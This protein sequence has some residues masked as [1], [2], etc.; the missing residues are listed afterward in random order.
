[1]TK[2]F[3]LSD[4]RDHSFFST[5]KFEEDKGFYY[6]EDVKEFIRRLRDYFEIPWRTQDKRLEISMN[7]FRLD[8]LKNINKLAGDK[9]K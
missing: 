7:S 1:M 4:K 5:K 8:V 6:E 2:E 3:N 9:L